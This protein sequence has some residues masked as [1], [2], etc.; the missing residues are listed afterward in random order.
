MLAFARA[1]LSDAAILLVD[2][3]T[4]SLDPQAADRIR[5]FLRSEMA[6]RQ[7]KTVLWATHD[8]GEAADCADDIA[9]IGRGR[10]R[11]SGPAASLA[12]GGRATLRRAY[13]QAIADPVGPVVGDGAAVADD[14][15]GTP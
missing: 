6:G 15:G 5:S 11:L 4:R 10:I 12:G 7:G 2:E 3:P 8:L 1:L 9:V 13:E 14:P